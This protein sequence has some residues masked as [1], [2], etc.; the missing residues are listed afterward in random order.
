MPLCGLTSSSTG[1]VTAETSQASHRLSTAFSSHALDPSKPVCPCIHY[2]HF[3][4]VDH[5]DTVRP[6]LSKGGNE[7]EIADYLRPNWAHL[8]IDDHV[9]RL[10][11]VVIG[12]GACGKV[13]LVLDRAT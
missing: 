8:S 9:V 12:D 5:S 4:S 1:G 6:G 2:L 3:H 10:Q 7:A 11:V 13:S